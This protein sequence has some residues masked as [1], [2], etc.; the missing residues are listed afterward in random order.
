M[1][2]MSKYIL[3][4]LIVLLSGS[5]FT[6]NAQNRK[7]IEKHLKKLTS[8]SFS[9]RGYVNKGDHKAAQYLAKQFE[10]YGLKKVKNSFFQPYELRMNTFPE[11][12]KIK[13]NGKRLKAAED[14]VVT[15]SSSKIK[16]Q[17][18]CIYLPLSPL[19]K[20]MDLSKTFLVGGKEQ[21]EL[22]KENPYQ[23]KGFIYLD[24]N[25]PIWSVWPG[26]DTSSYHVIK[27]R[28]ESLKDSIKDIEI[29]VE[30]DFIPH[31]Q[32]QN[33]WG[34]L[35]G[36][37]HPDSIIILGAHYDHLGKFGKAI[38][39]G[40]NDNA[41]GTVMILELANYFSKP[42]NQPDCSILFALFSG[43]EAGLLG[44]KYMAENFPFDYSQVKYM[45]NLDMVGAG[46]DGIKM[47]N[48]TEFP[49]IYNKMKELNE[50]KGY[51]KDVKSRGESC[52]SD[53]CP[54][55][56]K[57]IPAVFIYTLGNETKAYHIPEDDFKHL[58][59]T[60]FEDLFRLLRDFIED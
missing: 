43:E 3:S 15:A 16:G 26:K 21:K 10:D 58:P 39:R 14:F 23:S 35:S 54:F 42:E 57:E 24:E 45:I 4:F 34:M 51:L 32:T 29:K 56:E 37:S 6:L 9:G 11:T 50:E 36:K 25:Q 59:L 19:Q 12:P 38:Y 18:P 7:Q 52:N 33:V 5:F 30:P 1:R 28:K 48:A 47:V 41:S 20:E 2:K 22:L 49:F 8:A 55:Y 31:Y 27:L 60:E 17:Y 53:H 40:A 44:S 13:I 46:S